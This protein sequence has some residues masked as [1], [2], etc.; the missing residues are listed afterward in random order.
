MVFTAFCKAGR[1]RLLA[2]PKTMLV[3]KLTTILLLVGCLQVSAAGLAQKVSISTVNA[4]LKKVFK[5]I[6][7]Q[8]GY[9]FFYSSQLLE[10]AHNV[11]LSA[12]DQDLRKVLDECFKDQ[13]L[14]YNIVN[15]TIVVSPAPVRELPPAAQPDTTPVQIR[16]NGRIIESQNNTP[17]SGANITV[18]GVSKGAASGSTGDF[19]ILVKPGST[20]IISYVGYH[21]RELKIRDIS[22]L[23]I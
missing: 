22:F 17:L 18:K 3:M 21:T 16:V 9:T 2:K 23:E 10:D 7:R 11:T 5:E 12:N 13:P 14:V 15:R 19:S 1:F 20:L 8:T 4:P 6:K